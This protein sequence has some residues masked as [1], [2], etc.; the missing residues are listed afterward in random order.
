[1]LIMDLTLS[2]KAVGGCCDPEHEVKTLTRETEEIK[3][4][5]SLERC[6]NFL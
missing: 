5:L 6:I 4:E 3:Y 2:R 1:M